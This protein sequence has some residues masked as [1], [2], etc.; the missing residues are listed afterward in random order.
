MK[1]VRTCQSCGHTTEYKCPREYKDDSW[2]D[3]KCRRCKS[4]DLDYGREARDDE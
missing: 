1:W 4:V 2:R 3:V